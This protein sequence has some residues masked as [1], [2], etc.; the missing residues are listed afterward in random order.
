[1]PTSNTR[2]PFAGV[3]QQSVPGGG[4]WIQ[5]G[6]Y[7][8]KVKEQRYKRGHKGHS[9]ISE[10]EVL[11]TSNP[12]KHP[13]GSVVS[14]VV[15]IEP[16]SVTRDQ[17]GEPCPPTPLGSTKH[18]MGLGNIKGFLSHAC[19]APED[20]IT[21]SAIEATVDGQS[22]LRDTVLE[23]IAF[24]IPTK[25]PGQLFTKCNWKY[26]RG[27]FVEQQ[28]LL[29]AAA[30]TL[31]PGRQYA[32]LLPVEQAKVLALIESQKTAATPAV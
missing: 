29:A 17:N 16:E 9:Y 30:A 22:L 2:S 24:S 3:E 4:V 12:D 32:E 5:P 14:W 23:C 15:K 21:D 25:T 11:A 27:G 8:L 28:K 31:Y 26:L 19:A 20:S 13:V 1:M 10:F 7:D 18:S 6:K